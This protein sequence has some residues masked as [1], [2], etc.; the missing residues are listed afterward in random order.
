[1][2]IDWMNPSDD[3][4]EARNVGYRMA[5]EDMEQMQEEIDQLEQTIEMLKGVILEHEKDAE[6]ILLI[7]TGETLYAIGAEET[8]WF[9]YIGEDYEKGKGSKYAKCVGVHR[10]ELF[11]EHGEYLTTS[12]WDVQTFR[13]HTKWKKIAG[14]PTK[15]FLWRHAKHWEEEQKGKVQQS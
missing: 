6:N 3:L 7:L 5:E 1:M 14:E 10:A 8:Y 9:E 4:L 11:F 15:V 2:A 13:V 12:I